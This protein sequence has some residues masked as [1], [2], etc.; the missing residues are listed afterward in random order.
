MK[1]KQLDEYSKIKNQI[2]QDLNPYETVQLL[3]GRMIEKLELVIIAIDNNDLVAKGENIGTVITTLDVLLSVIDLDK[4]GDISTNLVRLY[5]YMM[6]TLIQANMDNSKQ[7]ITEVMNLINT[8]K[9]GWDG[10]EPEVKALQE[11]KRTK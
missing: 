1:R 9:T 6:N 8:I 4:G 11:A 10:I 3:Y 5:E 7:K 2:S